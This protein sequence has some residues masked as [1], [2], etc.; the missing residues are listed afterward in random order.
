[1]SS[2]DS[3]AAGDKVRGLDSIRFLCAAWVVFGHGLQPPLE[4]V[5]DRH[6]SASLFIAG[7][8]NNLWVG[9]AAVIVFFL[10][11]GFCIHYPQVATSRHPN[12]AA[13]Y[14]RRFL[15]LLI[16]MAVAIALGRL[17]HVTLLLFSDSILWSLLAEL[18]YYLLYPLLRVIRIRL[19]SWTPLLL[20]SFVASLLVVLTDP[21]AGNYPSYGAGLNWILGLPCWLLG[22]VLAEAVC[23]SN[24][25]P[26][27]ARTIWIWR[28]LLLGVAWLCSVLR[29]HTPI[30]FPWT[31]N[32]FALFAAL[33]LRREIDWF[34]RNPPLTWLERAGEWSYSLYLTHL[35]A[36]AFI[37]PFLPHAGAPWLPWLVSWL[38]ILVFAFVFYLL[39]ERPSHAL[40]RHASRKFA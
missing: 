30:G 36:I 13:F 1:V 20:A 19:G 11:S 5:F 23:K 9:P 2:S 7:L 17:T 21:R 4:S 34:R 24:A 3:T 14:T 31:L 29:Y 18:I 12:L 35:I 27:S 39:V 38:A 37:N 40:A 28:A 16:P 8:Y 32:F 22:C 6:S 10:V 33:W 25:L 26:I 15:R